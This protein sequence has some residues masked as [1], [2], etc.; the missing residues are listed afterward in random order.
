MEK[1]GS[2][3]WSI[4]KWRMRMDDQHEGSDYS[5][6]NASFA[7]KDQHAWDE[8]LYWARGVL[9]EAGLRI[10]PRSPWADREVELADIITGSG[11]SAC[12]HW[13]VEGAN[14][15]GGETS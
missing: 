15:A 6:S 4:Y 12:G 5:G 13:C 7:S 14:C 11:Q 3:Q 10:E 2:G 9:K 1:P 8:T